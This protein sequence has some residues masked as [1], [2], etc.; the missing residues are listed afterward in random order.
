MMSNGF[1][2]WM[3]KLVFDNWTIGWESNWLLYMMLLALR[4]DLFIGKSWDIQYSCEGHM[5]LALV[6][7]EDLF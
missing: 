2:E 7:Y 4:K 1:V 5:A 6:K 3:V